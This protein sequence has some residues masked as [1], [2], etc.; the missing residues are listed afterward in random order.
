MLRKGSAYGFIVGLVLLFVVTLLWLVFSQV[1]VPHL[2]PMADQFLTGYPEAHN[3]YE[4][5]K[6]VW[7]VWPVMIL[8]GII[9]YWFVNSQKEEP[10]ATQY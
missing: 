9:I 3:V 5:L 1:Y 4:L 8:V 7:N 6:T 10:I 2:F